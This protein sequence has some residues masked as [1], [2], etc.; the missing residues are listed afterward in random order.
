LA[1]WKRA[2]PRMAQLVVMRGR[3]MPRERKRAGLYLLTNISTSC[4]A[5][6]MMAM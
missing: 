4:T 6:A 1:V 2:R 5:E 3:K